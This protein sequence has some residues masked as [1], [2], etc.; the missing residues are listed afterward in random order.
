MLLQPRCREAWNLGGLTQDMSLDGDL[1]STTAWFLNQ[2]NAG[3]LK[4]PEVYLCKAEE[5][6]LFWVDRVLSPLLFSRADV[7]LGAFSSG[8]NLRPFIYIQE[9]PNTSPVNSKTQNHQE[10]A[11]QPTLFSPLIFS[12]WLTAESALP[13]GCALWNYFMLITVHYGGFLVI[14]GNRVPTVWR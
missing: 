3:F 10:Q 6:L 1:C 11:I 14:N 13:R 8:P 12:K 4:V 2:S 9:A 5:E 7:L